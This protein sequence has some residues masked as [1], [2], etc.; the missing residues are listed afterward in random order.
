MPSFSRG[1]GLMDNCTLEKGKEAKERADA[2]CISPFSSDLM[3]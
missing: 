3:A 1:S 2:L